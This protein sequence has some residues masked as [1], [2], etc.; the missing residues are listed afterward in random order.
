MHLSFCSLSLIKISLSLYLY[1]SLSLIASLFVNTLVIPKI[2]CVLVAV[3]REKNKAYVASLSFFLFFLRD[4][5]AAGA[6]ERI[7]SLRPSPPSRSAF[8]AVFPETPPLSLRTG[9]ERPSFRECSKSSPRRPP[10]RRRPRPRPRASPC[11]RS[12]RTRG[13]SSRAAGAPGL[14]PR[15]ARTSGGSR[16]CRR[17]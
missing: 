4:E 7:S 5:T 13:G 16:G 8:P 10:P 6:E 2:R 14:P 9:S 1:L 17:R 3:V 12:R 11:P 15:R